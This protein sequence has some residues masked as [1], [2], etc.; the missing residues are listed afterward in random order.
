MLD[1]KQNLGF[2][3]LTEEINR[4]G[5]YWEKS[6]PAQYVYSGQTQN[7]NILGK[8]AP[9]SALCNECPRAMSSGQKEK[10]KWCYRP[11]G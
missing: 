8:A 1:P 4:K 3:S 11:P 6:L 5:I 10:L 7:R 9:K 2:F